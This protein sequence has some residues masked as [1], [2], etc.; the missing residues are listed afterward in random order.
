MLTY[1]TNNVENSI[2]N[3]FILLFHIYMQMGS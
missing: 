2:Y 3:V 1:E